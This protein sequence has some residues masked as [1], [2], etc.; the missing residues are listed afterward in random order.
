M[1]QKGETLLSFKC[2]VLYSLLLSVKFHSMCFE[3]GKITFLFQTHPSSFLSNV[4][5]LPPE[6]QGLR[7]D[8]CN[9]LSEANEW[10]SLHDIIFE[11]WEVLGYRSLFNGF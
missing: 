6:K 4:P 1:I 7:E 5:E 3:L 8:L 11:V 2:V 9:L 10:E